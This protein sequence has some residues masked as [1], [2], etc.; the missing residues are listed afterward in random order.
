MIEKLLNEMYVAAPTDVYGYMSEYFRG[1]SKEPTISKLV[2]SQVLDDRGFSALEVHVLCTVAG[3]EKHV[4]SATVSLQRETEPF[5]VVA[6]APKSGTT[7]KKHGDKEKQ[8][9]NEQQVVIAKEECVDPLE[10]VAR[11]ISSALNGLT[12]KNQGLVDSTISELNA[13]GGCSLHPSAVLGASCAVARAGAIL[14]NVPLHQHIAA[15]CSVSRQS[16]ALPIPVVGAIGS[17]LVGCGKLRFLEF[18]LVPSPEV[19]TLEQVTNLTAIYRQIGEVLASKGGPIGQAVISNVGYCPSLDKAEQALDLLQECI[20]KAGLELN[21]HVTILIDAGAHR[22]FDKEK[23]KYEVIVGQWKSSDELTKL[24]CDI[25]DSYPGVLGFVNPLHQSDV[26]GWQELSQRLG[27]RCLLVADRTLV[28]LPTKMTP[29]ETKGGEDVNDTPGAKADSGGDKVE[30]SAL[31]YLSCATAVLDLTITAALNELNR[32]KG[33]S[34]CI[35]LKAPP[36]PTSD[37]II[38]D[39]AVATQCRFLRLG[40]PTG[41][42]SCSTVSRLLAIKEE[43]VLQHKHEPT[44]PHIFTCQPLVVET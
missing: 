41:V 42:T 33:C 15:L 6:A 18:C 43:L 44:K 35:M 13:G 39:L 23:L 8:L 14:G 4:C 29:P 36:I 31:S 12:V 16:F 21:N 9:E 3:V 10:S 30:P 19:S 32:L 37:P 34:H 24:Y 17:G 7:P 5:F 28:E 2:P 27:A 25:L 20:Q 11:L 22:F 38:A 1:L 26:Q 40:S